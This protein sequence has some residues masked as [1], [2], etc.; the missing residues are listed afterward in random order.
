MLAAFI[1]CVHPRS[2]DQIVKNNTAGKSFTDHQT[3]SIRQVARK[4]V[5]PTLFEEAGLKRMTP[6]VELFKKYRA[7]NNN[8]P[9]ITTV[10]LTYHKASHPFTVI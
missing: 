1:I 7:K 6:V 5:W 2:L 4:L 9:E 3:A 10:N 8:V